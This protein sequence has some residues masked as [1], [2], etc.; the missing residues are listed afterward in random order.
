MATPITNAMIPNS[1]AKASSRRRN[2]PGLTDPAFQY[3]K[4]IPGNTEYGW[5]SKWS[6]TRDDVTRIELQAG[7][8]S[9][10]PP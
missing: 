5:I 4:D 8:Y 1:V 9:A 10:G 3:G 6:Q 7:G 2:W